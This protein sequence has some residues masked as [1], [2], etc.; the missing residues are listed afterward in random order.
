MTAQ[1]RPMR[2]G[3][4]A[5]GPRADF[6]QRGPSRQ[7]RR[8]NNAPRRPPQRL[9]RQAQQIRSPLLRTIGRSGVTTRVRMARSYGSMAGAVVGIAS[10]ILP[11]DTGFIAP[12][13]WAHWQWG[14]FA[15]G[16]ALPDN[17]VAWAGGA[18]LTSAGVG[19]ITDYRDKQATN[20]NFGN[21]DR[22]TYMWRNYITSGVLPRGVAFYGGVEVLSPAHPAY[23][24]PMQVG[25]QFRPIE[26]IVTPVVITTPVPG[27]V[28]APGAAPATL[29]DYVPIRERDAGYHPQPLTDYVPDQGGLVTVDFRTDATPGKVRRRLAAQRGLDRAKQDAKRR[30]R[31]TKKRRERRPGR[32]GGPRTPTPK[33]RPQPPRVNV[34]PPVKHEDPKSEE[35]SK[36]DGKG[37]SSL[38][39]ATRRRREEKRARLRVRRR[40]GGAPARG[41]KPGSKVKERKVRT[42]TTAIAWGALSALTEAM[43]A[44]GAF[45]EA[46]PEHLQTARSAAEKYRLVYQHF[47]YIDIE[48]AVVNLIVQNAEDAIWAIEGRAAG[49]TS[50]RIGDLTGR[51]V[52]ISINNIGRGEIE[53]SRQWSA[54]GAVIDWL[55]LDEG[56]RAVLRTDRAAFEQWLLKRLGA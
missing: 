46:L 7:R 50:R 16:K 56:V 15:G 11:V 10:Q 1:N 29:D 19:G 47:R 32:P 37:N 39:G 27:A 49:A 6:R 28:T 12:P 21:V 42:K 9:V 52:G 44:L 53:A 51:P 4:P 30:L 36:I 38:K 43:D 31:E 14:T 40:K 22:R 45:Y 34:P 41:Q 13:A 55:A 26:K 5:Q 48:T 35:K 25:S 20:V 23:D 33:P 2:R 24:P 8:I 54:Q 3:Y 17:F 18:G